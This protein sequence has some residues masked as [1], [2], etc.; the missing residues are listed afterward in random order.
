MCCGL[1]GMTWRSRSWHNAAR[2]QAGLQDTHTVCCGR[3]EGDTTARTMTGPCDTN[4]QVG[5]QACCVLGPHE[6][7]LSST[8]TRSHLKEKPD[9]KWRL[10]TLLTALVGACYA[11]ALRRTP[12]QDLIYNCRSRHSLFEASHTP[13]GQLLCQNRSSGVRLSSFIFGHHMRQFLLLGI[14][15]LAH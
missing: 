3:T 4:G 2:K 6:G 12:A 13:E 7:G 5:K 8:K 11:P 9:S 10:F 15:G 14:S 1:T